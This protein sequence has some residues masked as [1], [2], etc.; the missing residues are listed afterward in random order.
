MLTS[1]SEPT[2]AICPTF[3]QLSSCKLLAP[4]MVKSVVRFTGVPLPVL[5]VAALIFNVS[6]VVST[7]VPEVP[8]TVTVVMPVIA[9]DVALKVIVCELPEPEN[10]AVTPLGSEETLSVTVPPKPLKSVMVMAAGAVE[11]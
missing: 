1:E 3:S 9:V 6:A 8:V 7:M 11:V 5:P 4:L 10:V 2:A